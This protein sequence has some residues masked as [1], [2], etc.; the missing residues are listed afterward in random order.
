MPVIRRVAQA[1]G[2]SGARLLHFGSRLITPTARTRYL[3]PGYSPTVADV[4]TINELTIPATGTLSALY[5]RHNVAGVGGLITYTVM[6]NGVATSL[7]VGMLASATTG[8]NT[9]TNISVMAGQRV[10]VRVTK[11]ALTSG[12][13]N[14]HVTMEIS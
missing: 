1:T 4:E 2:G 7:A 6:V 9:T 10:A 12:P 5:V 3:T 8:Q 14:V 13:R 11:S